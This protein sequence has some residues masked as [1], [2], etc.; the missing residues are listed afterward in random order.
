MLF[1]K[2]KEALFVA[3]VAFVLTGALWRVFSGSADAGIEGDTRTEMIL[4]LMYGGVALLAVMQFRWTAWL[5]LHSP[6]LVGLLLVALV[7]PIWAQTPDLVFRRA[8]SLL[9]T[10]LFGVVIASRL[11]FGQQLRLTRGVLRLAAVGCL[12]L[13]VVAPSHAMATDYGTGSIRGIFPH[14]NLFGAAMALGLLAEWY[15]MEEGGFGRIVKFASLALFSGLLLV[16]RSVTSIVTV[17]GTLIIM[18]LYERFHRRYHI[19][20]PA[21]LLFLAGLAVCFAF[22]GV[23][24]SIFTEMLGRSKDLTGRADLWH[25]VG[26]MILARPFLGY[27]FSGFWDGASLESYAVE[28]YVGWSPNYSHNGYLEILLD[29]GIV[30]TGLFLIFL[31]KGMAR[32]LRLAEE[33]VV[34][35]DLWPLAFLIFFVVHNF[36]ECTIIWQNC[37]EWSLCIATVISSDSTVRAVVGGVRE[38]SE[39]VSDDSEPQ[40]SFNGARKARHAEPLTLGDYA[41]R[42]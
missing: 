23:D 27:G 42:A 11:T 7:S 29:L 2:S 25:S 1:E 17:G 10:S 9:G 32:T 8:I 24:T 36:A 37:F 14:K 4:A 19:P 22:F 38:L 12:V 21:M 39:T 15:V 26:T 13:F 40:F 18:W 28:K 41:N 30:G 31:W 3:V 20:L 34:K 5:L 16:A 35:E 6:A 33:K